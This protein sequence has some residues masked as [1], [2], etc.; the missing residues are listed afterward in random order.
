MWSQPYL[1]LSSIC[2]NSY[3]RKSHGAVPKFESNQESHQPVSS[4]PVDVIL[5][6]P[7]PVD[8]QGWE[9]FCLKNYGERRG[10][11]DLNHVKKYALKLK[12]VGKKLN[13]PVLDLFEIFEKSENKD[14]FY[15][16]LHLSSLGN[17][18]V[19]E[20]LMELVKKYFPSKSPEEEGGVK[21]EEKLWSELC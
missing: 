19:F 5:I 2:L 6:T 11:R 17:R 21:L 12:E 10:K 9:D 3:K 18:L 20:G 8:P 13:C 16:G 7:P 1:I 15:D 4:S 14:F